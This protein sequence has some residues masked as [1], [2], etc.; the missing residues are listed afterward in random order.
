LVQRN[1]LQ[2]LR[3]VWRGGGFDLLSVSSRQAQTISD[4]ENTSSVIHAL[5]LNIVDTDYK[6]ESY[7]QEFR[8]TSTD[9]ASDVQWR[10][11]FLLFK[12]VARAALNPNCSTTPP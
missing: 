10:T 8:A 7:T 9:A 4:L 1:N 6:T 12:S 3:V 11:G 2:A 5:P